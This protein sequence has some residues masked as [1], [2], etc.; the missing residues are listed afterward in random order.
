[1]PFSDG[2]NWDVGLPKG[3]SLG[4]SALE[5]GGKGLDG[6]AGEGGGEREAQGRQPAAAK[7][8]EPPG[9]WLPGQA[10]SSNPPSPDEKTMAGGAGGWPDPLAGDQ[11]EAEAAGE[12]GKE[13]RKGVQPADPGTRSPQPLLDSTPSTIAMTNALRGPGWRRGGW[14]SALRGCG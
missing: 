10:S 8:K 7:S 14:G 1:M 4:G 5:A 3:R 11:G 13:D 12:A 6:D 2:Q 9:S